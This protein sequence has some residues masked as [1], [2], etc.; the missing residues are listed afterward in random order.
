MSY[1]CKECGDSFDSLRSL[2]AHIKKHGKYL[3]DY[4]VENY[5]RKDRL[6]GELIPFKKYKQYFD[7]EFINKR[8][9]R[10]WC[11]TAPV[12]EAKEFITKSLKESLHQD[13]ACKPQP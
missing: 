3:G 6:T 10:K 2:H 4:Y 13:G 9:M 12:E 11:S 7:S 1:D 5:A 8:N